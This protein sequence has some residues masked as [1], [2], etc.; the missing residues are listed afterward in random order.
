[1]MNRRFVWFC[2]VLFVWGLGCAAPRPRDWPVLD[3]R[4]PS[5]GLIFGSIRFSNPD[6]SVTYFSLELP[7]KFYLTRRGEKVHLREDGFFFVEN[8]QPGTYRITAVFSGKEGFFF[9]EEEMPEFTVEKD[10]VSFAGSY[11]V[12]ALRGGPTL[13]A[14]LLSARVS[15]P[16][17]REL[18]EALL[19]ETRGT[20]WREKAKKRLEKLKKEEQPSEGGDSQS[21]PTSAPQ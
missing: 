9:P 5:R 1:M 20:V 21:L 11:E 19:E 15:V 17:E 8:L 10:N 7:Y 2:L 16:T 13:K 6:L 4:S 18:L 12:T 14:G 3:Q